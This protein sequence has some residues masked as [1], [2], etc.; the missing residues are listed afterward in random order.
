MSATKSNMK[1]VFSSA[2]FAAGS[3]EDELKFALGDNV[4]NQIFDDDIDEAIRS[5][6][7][8]NGSVIAPFAVGLSRSSSQRASAGG[9]DCD[10]SALGFTPREPFQLDEGASAGAASDHLGLSRLVTMPGDDGCDGPTYVP[11]NDAF[12]SGDNMDPPSVPSRASSTTS[13]RPRR[14]SPGS[15]S[16]GAIPTTTPRP[17]SSGG[18]QVRPTNTPAAAAGP[19]PSP[20]GSASPGPAGAA[21]GP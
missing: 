12:G 8:D 13:P 4:D 6:D 10:A 21:S 15:S 16:L 14:S 19:R 11:L 9:D 1:F 3:I 2:I 5:A 17:R 7:G 18:R 20:R